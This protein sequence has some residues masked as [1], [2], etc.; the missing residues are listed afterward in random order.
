MAKD[1]YNWEMPTAKSRSGVFL[2]ALAFAFTGLFVGFAPVG[3][4][5]GNGQGAS[6]DRG[7]SLR[8]VA[9]PVDLEEGDVEVEQSDPSASNFE[10][11]FTFYK[12]AFEEITY[13]KWV[14]REAARLGG[15]NFVAD[16]PSTSDAFWYGV[17]SPDGNDIQHEI[18]HKGQVTQYFVTD[19][20]VKSLTAQFNGQGELLHVNGVSPQ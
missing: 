8:S 5:N 13:D 19:D 11:E 20:E 1:T 2:V 10:E 9:E 17:S 15:D 14:Y 4:Q 18:S 16:S 7:N 3:A 12:V 6:P